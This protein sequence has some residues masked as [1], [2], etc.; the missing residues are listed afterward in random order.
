MATKASQSPLTVGS[1]GSERSHAPEEGVCCRA[2]YLK[3][4]MTL[5]PF[6]QVPERAT[7][8]Q[9]RNQT[10]RQEKKKTEEGDIWRQMNAGAGT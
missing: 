2:G 4:H 3:V 6:I 5:F 1:F 10:A 7:K 9:R 8:E